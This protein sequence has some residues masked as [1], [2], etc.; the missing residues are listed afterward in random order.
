MKLWRKTTRRSD[1]SAQ[2]SAAPIV[3]ESPSPI[4][5]PISA[6][7]RSVTSAERSRVSIRTMSAPSEAPTATSTH[8]A[9]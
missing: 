9:G 4:A 6:P 8:S 2:K 5:P 3:F 1:A 7:S